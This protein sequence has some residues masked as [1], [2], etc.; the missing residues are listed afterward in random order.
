MKYADIEKLSIDELQEK[1]VEA[2]RRLA[3]LKFD[4]AIAPLQNPMQIRN[5][6]KDIARM[7][8]AITA[9][10]NAASNNK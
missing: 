7:L 3:S 1:V 5:L 9:K 8:T 2:K 6:K 10:Q 4:H